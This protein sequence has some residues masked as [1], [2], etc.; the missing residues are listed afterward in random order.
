[1]GLLD[2]VLGAVVN[3]VTQSGGAASNLGGG[4][5]GNLMSIAANN[6]QLV[7]VVLE[8]LD[9]QKSPVGGL[10]G[11]VERFQQAGLGSLVASWL[12]NGPNAALSGEQ[13]GRVLGQG[14]LA[15]IAAQ[16]GV[17]Q[18]DASSQLSQLLP[19]LIDQL[20]PNGQLPASVQSAAP[21]LLG[22][23]GNLLKPR[24]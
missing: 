16:L 3:G 15:Q 10:P 24:A 5:L 6:P 4:G 12:G 9:P 23:L 19:G 11:L 18:S 13:L 2:S 22:L 17:G 21:Q 20:T 1:M 8:L 14:P 7:Q